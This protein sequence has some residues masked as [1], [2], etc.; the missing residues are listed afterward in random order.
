VPCTSSSVSFCHTRSRHAIDYGEANCIAPALANA[1][2][3]GVHFQVDAGSR[4]PTPAAS[5]ANEPNQC[6]GHVRSPLRGL[7]RVVR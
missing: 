4:R 7:D 2:L 1:E 6:R 3:R 5:E